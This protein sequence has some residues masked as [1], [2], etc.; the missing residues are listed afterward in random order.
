M[1]PQPEMPAIAAFTPHVDQEFGV[2]IAE[3][4]VDLGK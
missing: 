1:C 4:E 3:Y 2:T